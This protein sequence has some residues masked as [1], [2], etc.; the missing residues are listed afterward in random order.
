MQ[1]SANFQSPP[2]S[3]VFFCSCNNVYP[4]QEVRLLLYL[5]GQISPDNITLIYWIKIT[6]VLL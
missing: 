6:H 3:V 2:I 1:S 5:L 4:K